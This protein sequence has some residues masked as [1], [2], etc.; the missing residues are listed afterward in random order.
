MRAICR[1]AGALAA[2]A[3]VAAASAPYAQE[4][5]LTV[6]NVTVT[7]PPVPVQPPYLRDPW[8]SYERN[9]YAGRYRVEEDKFAK[10]PCNVTRI[11]S[12]AGGNCL[13]G[14]RLTPGDA[15]VTNR[16]GTVCDMALD[17]VMYN[18]GNLSVEASTLIF[19]PYKVTAIGFSA[20]F[21]YVN[22]HL[23]YDQEDFRDMNQMTRRGTN[24]RNLVS[25][26]EEKSIEFSDGPHNCVAVHKPGPPWRGGYVYMMHAS[27]CRTDTGAVRAEDISYAL[28]LLQIRQYDPV[29]NLR[30][31]G[32]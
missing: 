28:G 27:I 25:N 19:D 29:G 15:I 22:A 9:P 3:I 2:L 16:T 8:K 21:C 26:G 32:E 23:G 7:A 11:A 6:P 13:Q 5:K 20:K 4:T 18:V 31:A 10:V 17:V 14:Y 24:W 30:K 12:S 1:I